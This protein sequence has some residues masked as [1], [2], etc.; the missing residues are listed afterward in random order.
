MI[1]IILPALIA[2]FFIAF[3]SAPLGCFVVWRKM[4]YF[5]D[6]LSHATL[7]GIVIGMA[8]Q[9]NLMF[10]STFFILILAL[11]LVL[12]ETQK[13]IAVDTLLGILSHGALSIGI[14]SMYFIGFQSNLVE[15]YLLGDILSISYDDLYFIIPTVFIIG[16][17]LI[18]HW[19]AF[20]YLTLDPE[21]AQSHGIHLQKNKFIFTIL[22]AVTIGIAFKFIGALVITALLIIPVAI[23]RFFSK[24]PEQMAFMAIFISI[25]MILLG[26]VVSA[27]C[28]TPSGPSIVALCAILFLL[29]LICD[30]MHK[31]IKKTI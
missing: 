4:A 5:G 7:L 25:L 28:D 15:N 30:L 20:L 18:K 8:L 23:A 12:L 3:I 22:L 24:T 19:N 17:I 26:F 31:K 27:F 10:A 14:V 16:A 2:G 29:T 11:L 9:W 13:K 1:E 21:L 6:T